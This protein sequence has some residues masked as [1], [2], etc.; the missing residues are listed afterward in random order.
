MPLGQ[1][2]PPVLPPETGLKRDLSSFV[3]GA[4]VYA[5]A[6]TELLAI[7]GKEA[8]EILGKKGAHL[9]ASL[10]FGTVGYLLLVAGCVGVLTQILQRQDGLTFNNW[11]GASLILG[12]SHLLLSGLIALKAKGIGAQ[13]KLFEHT[14]AEWQKDQHWLEN[15]KRS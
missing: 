5:Q 14:L 2:E 15:E 12:L 13:T 9:I 11:I 1:S 8:G 3:D 7:E 4:K 10:L 6:R